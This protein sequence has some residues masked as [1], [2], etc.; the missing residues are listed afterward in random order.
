MVDTQCSCVWNL[1]PLTSHND[2]EN[3][4]KEDENL[5]D[6]EIEFG[7]AM[8]D[9]DKLTR[10]MRGLPV[11]DQYI[12]LSRAFTLKDWCWLSHSWWI[13]ELDG[14]GWGD[15]NTNAEVNVEVHGAFRHYMEVVL[16]L[17]SEWMGKVFK[18]SASTLFFIL[19]HLLISTSQ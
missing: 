11:T 4:I 8:K 16:I 3:E 17:E 15:K 7:G 18:T 6:E 13:N 9:S 19:E 1:E 10:Y 12:A 2:E 5:E 14:G